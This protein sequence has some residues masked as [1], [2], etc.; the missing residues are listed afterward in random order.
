MIFLLNVKITNVRLHNMSRRYVAQHFPSDDRMDVFK[1][2]LMSHSVMLPLISKCVFYIEIA[3]D[4]KYRRDELEEYILKIFPKNKIILNWYRNSFG[5]D[6]INVCHQLMDIDD[7]IIWYAANDDHIFIDNSINLVKDGLEIIKKDSNP[8]SFIYYSH[9]PEQIRLANQLNAE[10]VDN[11]NFVK[12]KWHNYDALMIMKKERFF[13]YWIGHDYKQKLLYKS[14]ELL[15][16]RESYDSY[17]YTPTKEI[18][19]HY[20]GY[21][22]IG[23]FNN[24]TPPLIIPYGFFENSINIRYGFEDRRDDYINLNPK[25]K[26]LYSVDKDGADYRW[27]IEDIPLFW[28]NKINEYE[29][30]ENIDLNELKTYR[31][32]YYYESTRIPMNAYY[33]TFE[34]RFAPLKWFEK[35]LLK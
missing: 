18:V 32:A 9:W 1:Y 13:D 3:D 20:D 17:A 6:W 21:D 11:G 8:M 25:S 34:N 29:I 26:N 12:Y 33:M 15:F 14:D 35:H 30:N 23:D 24:L 10:L 27:C 2:F 4:L 31:N 7:D 5:K 28:K 19:R 22:H 16:D